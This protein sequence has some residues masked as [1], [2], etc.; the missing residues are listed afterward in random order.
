MSGLGRKVF[1]ERSTLA[2][3]DVQGY[4]MD[5]AVMRF[6]SAAARLAEV[7]APTEGMFSTL[8]DTDALYRHSGAGWVR[9]QNGGWLQN[10]TTDS[11]GLYVFAHGLGAAPRG[12]AAFASYQLNDALSNVMVVKYWGADATNIT[13]RAYRTDTSVPFGTTTLSFSW[14]AVA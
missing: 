2:S 12:V 5:Q 8:D 4:L 6:S 10:V 3:A 14:L 11:I 9:S 1:P 7:P 13:V